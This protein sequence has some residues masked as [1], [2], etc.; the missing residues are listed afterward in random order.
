MEQNLSRAINRF[1]ASP[2]LS[3]ISWKR[4]VH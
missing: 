3:R 2:K 1:S 4:Y